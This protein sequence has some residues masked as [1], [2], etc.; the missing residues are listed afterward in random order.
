MHIPINVLVCI[1]HC[2]Q[3][4]YWASESEPSSIVIKLADFSVYIT[5]YDI[6]LWVFPYSTISSSHAK[7][8]LC[9][10]YGEPIIIIYTTCFIAFLY[11]YSVRVGLLN[12][13]IRTSLPFDT[14]TCWLIHYSQ[15]C[16][17]CFHSLKMFSTALIQNCTDEK[18]AEFGENR[19]TAISFACFIY[20][21]VWLIL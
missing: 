6:L 21:L 5:L 14:W 13:Q 17:C 11:I 4:Y 8:L 10:L 3:L 7:V 12:V 2:V 1:N 19:L 9:V 15:C 20:M 16:C 18:M